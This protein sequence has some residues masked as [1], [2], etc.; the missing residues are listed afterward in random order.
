MADIEAIVAGRRDEPEKGAVIRELV[1]EALDEHRP[2]RSRPYQA[3][4]AGQHI[5]ELRQFVQAVL[6]HEAA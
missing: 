6:P 3:H 4:V 1:A 2:L 5:E